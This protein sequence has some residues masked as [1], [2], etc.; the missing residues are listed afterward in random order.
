MRR[1]TIPAFML[2][3]QRDSCGGRGGEKRPEG[4][5]RPPQGRSG[6][7]QQARGGP[8][9]GDGRRAA[10]H[11]ESDRPTRRPDPDERRR[12]APGKRRKGKARSP[13]RSGAGAETAGGAAAQRP[14]R[15]AGRSALGE[16]AQGGCDCP[17]AT[18]PPRLPAAAGSA[19]KRAGRCPRAANAHAAPGQPEGRRAGRARRAHLFMLRRSG[20]AKPPRRPTRAGVGGATSG[21]PSPRRPTHSRLRALQGGSRRKA[22]PPPRRRARPRTS[23]AGLPMIEERRRGKRSLLRPRPPE[24][25]PSPGLQHL[26]PF[27]GRQAGMWER[28]DLSGR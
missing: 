20:R 7:N 1:I 6:G 14:P 11:R 24:R 15:K 23:A 22:E 3:L 9:A 25:L 2:F 8:C 27:S 18:G 21:L 16:D 13:Q 10:K 17:A 5:R 26:V 19:D 4:P 28:S 12:K